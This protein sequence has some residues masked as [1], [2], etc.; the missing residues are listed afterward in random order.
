[1]N[2][3]R[4]E[5]AEEISLQPLLRGRSQQSS[6]VL[7]LDPDGKRLYT[8]L[9]D[10]P[11]IAV[12]ALGSQSSRSLKIEPSKVEG[13]IPVPG[14]PQAVG[15]DPQGTRLL[16]ALTEPVDWQGDQRILAQGSGAVAVIELPAAKE[17]ESWLNSY[18]TGHS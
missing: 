16:V 1:M 7:S 3:Q 2:E 12:I 10:L 15:L 8:A 13:L 4:V 6:V 18:L 11:W 17:W 5:V 9:T 14:K